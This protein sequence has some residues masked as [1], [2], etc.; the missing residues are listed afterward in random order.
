VVTF[1]NVALVGVVLER[2]EAR[3][4]DV[5]TGL[6][7][8][9]ARLPAIIFY[10]AIAATVG[11]ALRLIQER[12]GWIGQIIVALIGMVWS[13]AVALVVPVLAA[14]EIGPIEAIRRSGE[15]I[16]Q[17]WGEGLVSY[18]SIG[19]VTGLAIALTVL[20]GGL[21]TIGVLTHDFI[22]LALLLGAMTALAVAVLVLVQATLTTINLAVLYRFAN[23]ELT[24]GY[25]QE[26][27]A[28]AFRP[29]K[30]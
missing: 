16:K 4:A 3:D 25:D 18:G 7:L 26:L 19:W 28:G 11:M 9:V 30:G 1:F 12:V 8:A 2:L 15:L 6:S 14:E 27:L 22:A 20:V 10:A 5:S 23:G 13:V 21:A 29:K 17:S 24:P